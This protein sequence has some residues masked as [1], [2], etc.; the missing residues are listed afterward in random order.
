VLKG[1]VKAGLLESLC[2]EK[3]LIFKCVLV[4][5]HKSV[6]NK[7]AIKPPYQAATP[8]YEDNAVE[9]GDVDSEI[10]YPATPKTT[11]PAIPQYNNNYYIFLFKQFS[12]FWELY[13]IKKAEQQ[14]WQVFQELNPSEA[15]IEQILSA[16]QAQI[17]FIQRQQAQG[18]WV[19]NW[20]NPANWLTQL[21][22]KDELTPTAK[23][24]T[25]ATYETRHPKHSAYDPLWVICQ[26]ANPTEDDSACEDE[27]NVIQFPTRCA[28]AART[29]CNLYS[30]R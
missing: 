1:L 2:T 21:C 17:N 20:K 25:Y 10:T 7:L 8:K 12:R 15:L 9:I 22:W 4:E 5:A 16:L 30:H 11:Q 26:G 6:Q 27:S 29:R 28:G 18:H 19:P 23:E 24:T 13:P 14:A 3:N